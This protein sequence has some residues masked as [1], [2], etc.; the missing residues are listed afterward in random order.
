MKYFGFPKYEIK[1]ITGHSSERELEAYDSG[2]EDEMFGMSPAISK[3]T[4]QYLKYSTSTV[5][6]KKKLSHHHHRNNLNLISPG[7]FIQHP[8][9]TT[10]FLTE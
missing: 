5:A 7:F 10:T 2:K 3:C 6:P 1:N 4:Q 9:T 8:S